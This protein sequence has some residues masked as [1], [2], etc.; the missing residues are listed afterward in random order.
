ME[1]NTKI[2]IGAGVLALAY[3]L[4]NA[5]KAAKGVTISTAPIPSMVT[6]QLPP[7]AAPPVRSL[8]TV[9]ATPDIV[10]PIQAEAAL[11]VKQEID[12]LAKVKAQ[13]DENARQQA[14]I[15]AQ[16]KA[17]QEAYLKAQADIKAKNDAEIAAA[18]AITDAAAKAKAEAEAKVAADEAARQKAMNAFMYPTC[19]D[20]FEFYQNNCMPSYIVQEQKVTAQAN[21][22]EG[23][24]LRDYSSGV[25]KMSLVKICPDGYVKKGINCIPVAALS[26]QEL[27]EIAMK[28]AG[29]VQTSDGQWY[30]DAASAAAAQAR[31]DVSKAASIYTE[32]YSERQKNI[33][34]AICSVDTNG[35]INSY[36]AV[37]NGMS[38]SQY[39]GQYKVTSAELGV[40]RRSC[41]KSVY[42]SGRIAGSLTDDESEAYKAYKYQNI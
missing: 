10:S 42:S 2:L 4:Y 30:K 27:Q 39:I 35:V 7:E 32:T 12:R 41:P 20:G 8:P 34:S 6:N 3:Y 31:I 22:G 29:M 5:S 16:N 14:I 18:K 23:Y 13:Q 24:I 19:P 37:T 11:A 26:P 36:S 38:L 15:D 25:Q 21:N 28:Q 33:N 17:N 1:K 9:V 40:A